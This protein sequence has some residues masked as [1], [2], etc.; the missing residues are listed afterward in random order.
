M[1][2]IVSK[3]T[4]Q[5]IKG[6]LDR[7]GEFELSKKGKPK[8]IA[9]FGR[10]A[11]GKSGYADAIEYLFSVDGEVEHLGKGSADSEQGG[12]HALPHVLAAEKGIVPQVSANF[13]DINTGESVS[14]TR[15][16]I[17]G[18]NDVR[19]NELTT[20]LEKAPAYRVLRQ[21]D[22]RRFVVDMTPG[23]KFEEFARWIGLKSATTVLKHLTT[24]EGTLRDTSVDREIN[25]R[26]TSIQEHTLGAVNVF[27]VPEILGWCSIEIGKQL[28]QVFSVNRVQEIENGVAALKAKREAIINQTQIAKAGL[29]NASSEFISSDGYIKRLTNDFEKTIWAETKRDELKE[30]AK[31]SIFQEVWDVSVAFLE[32]HTV[33]NCPICQTP[34]ATT[35]VGS[36]ENAVISLH[37]SQIILSD[38]KKQEINL[39]KHIQLVKVNLQQLETRLTEIS[40]YA[41][42]ISLTEIQDKSDEL[43]S[44]TVFYQQSLSS[45]VKTK[46]SIVSLLNDCQVLAQKAIPFAIEQIKV[47]A[48]VSSTDD[49]DILISHLQ[50]LSES[51]SRLE[52]LTKRQN[53]IRNVEIA[54][55]KIADKIRSE[56]KKVADNAVDALKGDVQ[57]I[58]KKIHPGEAVPNVFIRLNTEEKTLTIRVNFHSN[59]RLVPP[60]GYLSEAQINTLGLSLFL[61]SVRLFNKEF[62]FVFLDDIVSS[63]DADNRSR[64]VDVLAEDMNEFQILLTTH[65]ERFYTHLRGRLESENWS[66]ERISSC[67]FESGPRRESDNLRPE[68]INELIAQGDEKIAGNA[69]RQYME[70]WFDTIC[71]KYWVYTPHKKGIRE[72]KRTLSDYWE[73]FVVRLGS[74]KADFGKYVLATETYKRFQGGL[75]P[76]INYYSH[77]QTNPYEWAAMG[78]VQYIWDEFQKFTDLF[79]CANCKKSLQYD[80]KDTK[81]YCTC[82]GMIMPTILNEEVKP[83]AK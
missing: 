68:Q 13:I 27:D 37:K 71:E 42:A 62:P 83:K 28:G 58:Y 33:E 7:S 74:V 12:K 29:E 24:V 16:V 4:I 63:Y 18:R 35:V 73:P 41:K 15:P 8:S 20:L 34:W 80:F 48:T 23:Q 57:K 64:I 69:V 76:I 61:S 22:L 60:G 5:G 45:A 2:W 44:R 52:T 25:E 14:I 39:Q 19:P 59:E 81:F 40:S 6:V 82:G 9:V 38:L 54:F 10:N 66:F 50:G 75:M 53:S 30:K 72:Y 46:D 36:Q 47:D 26:L 49:I 77:N 17:T 1:T 79:K 43:H 21:H 67:N 70:D 3:I 11:H 65:D 56:T 55:G 51:L 78:D 31:E 32:N